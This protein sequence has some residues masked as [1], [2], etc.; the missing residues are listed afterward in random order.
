MNPVI[1]EI[2]ALGNS[3]A[4]L[5]ISVKMKTVYYLN[6]QAA[7]SRD[8]HFSVSLATTLWFLLFSV[9]IKSIGTDTHAPQ[10]PANADSVS[11]SCFRRR[12]PLASI[13]I[14]FWLGHW[15]G[16]LHGSC[17]ASWRWLLFRLHT[18][19]FNWRLSSILN[20]ASDNPHLCFF[21]KLSHWLCP[22]LF[23][24]YFSEVL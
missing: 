1:P 14:R 3:A 17:A 10:H 19:R 21:G 15:F 2:R 6:L 9:V 20:M 8:I 5:F 16:I 13:R 7:S 23:L 18:R 4:K 12:C 11:S 24:L 22:C